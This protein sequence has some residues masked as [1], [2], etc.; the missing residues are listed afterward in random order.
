MKCNTVT[1]L[2]EW[3]EPGGVG[4]TNTRP[5][6]LHWLVGDTVLSK[7]AADHFTLDLNRIEH[8]SVVDT[9][10]AAYHLRNDD[11]SSQVS[12]NYRGLFSKW[13]IL[14]CFS[15]LLEQI[16]K[17]FLQSPVEAPSGSGCDQL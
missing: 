6:M 14:L 12:L 5:T 16:H 1:Q 10:D 13:D 17:W 2:F 7:V 9:N 15:Q 8:L 3:D 4:G 11:H